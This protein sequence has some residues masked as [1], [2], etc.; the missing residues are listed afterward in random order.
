MAKSTSNAGKVWNSSD[1]K[2]VVE[3]AR[4]N[5]PTGVI[6][7]KL[8]RSENAIRAKAYGLGV[9]LKPTNQKPYNR[10]AK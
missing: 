3:L 10:K 6:G 2:K 7:L 8:K 5:T 4:K 1:E 9:S